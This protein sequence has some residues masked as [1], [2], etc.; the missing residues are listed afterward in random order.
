MSNGLNRYRILVIDDNPAI[1]D[2]FRK[3]LADAPTPSGV[4]DLES[5]LFGEPEAMD[6]PSYDVDV[7][8]QGDEG[9]QKIV[10]AN[11]EGRPYAMVFT[12]MRMPPGWDGVQT[13]REI[14]KTS[15][16][17][18]AAICTAYSD[19]TPE[20][21]ASELGVR[22]RMVIIR[23]PFD[24]TEI[25][26]IAAMVCEKW[27]LSRRRQNLEKEV[28]TRTA[29]LKRAA[30][31]DGLT[32]LPN[33]LL[34]ADRLGQAM[35]RAKREPGYKFAVLFVDC[36]NFKSVNDGLGHHAGDAL[37]RQIAQRLQAAIRSTDTV[38]RAAVDD[39][40][41][42]RVG[43][44]EFAL[45]LTDI[46]ADEDAVRVAQRLIDVSAEPYTLAGQRVTSRMSVG[47][48]TNGISYTTAEEM[49]RDADAAMYAAKR[50]GRGRFVVFDQAMHDKAVARLTTENELRAAVENGCVRPHFQP[51]IA[52][53][54][55]TLVGFEALA[56]WY[57]PTR[58]IVLPADFIP[59]AEETGI[60]VPL[61]IKMLGDAC[62][63]LAAWQ[64][65]F[66]GLPNLTMSVNV[67]RKQ[68]T[69]PSF[70][71]EVVAVVNAAG[72]LPKQI[73]L[74]ITE[75]T[76]M[77]DA[78]RASAV[79]QQLRNMNFKLHMDDFGSGYSSL[80]CLSNFPLSGLKIDGAF[81]QQM[82]T[83]QSGTPVLNAVATLAQGLKVP[84][85]AEGVEDDA[86]LQKLKS[87]G[88]DF[89]QGYLI[90]PPLDATAATA[91]LSGVSTA[92]VSKAA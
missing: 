79:L 22:G 20:Q 77:I 48:T 51:I 86:Q 53:E 42:A 10:A 19:Y 83:S 5:A 36:D 92:T 82:S 87:M 18:Q 91:F 72:V 65:Q 60:I 14:W 80:S 44:D 16:G 13:L 84:V 35:L 43:G 28:E 31:H 25:R 49:I 67:S 71:E 41:A 85:V 61:G 12:D 21:I 40:I 50:G 38:S 64:K 17:Q 46:R 7:A 47:V 66:P 37:L 59:L 29:D 55:R 74:E 75:S 89:A 15:P 58:G 69:W 30:L 27:E 68:L 34:F 57:H 62:R 26:Q 56:R 76:M 24:A 88:F 2:D 32:G 9:L 6:S 63:Q 70:V 73:N 45:L 78:A 4:D 81:L 8:H 1:H 52:T 11:T 23:K 39:A 33:R 90:A 54:T 3:V